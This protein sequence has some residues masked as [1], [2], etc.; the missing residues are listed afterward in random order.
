MQM[1]VSTYSEAL[2]SRDQFKAPGGNPSIDT[3]LS[4]ACLHEQ[5][6]IRYPVRAYDPTEDAF[7]TFID[8]AGI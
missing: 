4:K 1:N 5:S 2:I 8:G 6:Q 3:L 7:E